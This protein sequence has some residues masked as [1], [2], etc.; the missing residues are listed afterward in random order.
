MVISTQSVV[1]IVVMLLVIVVGLILIIMNSDS[2][3]NSIARTFGLFN[4]FGTA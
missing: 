2:I 3:S 1:L 4:L